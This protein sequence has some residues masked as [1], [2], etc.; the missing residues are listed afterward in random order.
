MEILEL[1]LQALAASG[2]HGERLAQIGAPHGA[3]AAQE[4]RVVQAQLQADAA[5]TW[6][7]SFH[8]L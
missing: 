3:E 5:E 2:V 1:R 6:N 7:N 4:L 8:M